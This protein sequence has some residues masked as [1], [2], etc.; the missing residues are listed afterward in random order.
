M[1]NEK[2]IQRV[3][4]ADHPWLGLTPF[5][6][7]TKKYFFGRDRAIRDLF[8]RVREQPLT[9]LYG[10]SR[11]GKTSL[12]CAGL[13]PILEVEGYRPCLIRLRYEA[14]DTSVLEQTHTVLQSL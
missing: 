4:D 9:L 5:T 10:Q 3:V 11:L 8:L 6:P 14:I 1:S 7:Q 13:I 2:S 12:L